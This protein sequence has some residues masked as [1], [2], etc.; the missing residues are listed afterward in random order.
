[1]TTRMRAYQILLAED[2]NPDILLVQAAL[3]RLPLECAVQVIR[4]GAQAVNYIERIDKAYRRTPLDLALVDLYLPGQD[5]ETVIRR[6]RS[7]EHYAQ[8]PVIVISGSD[9]PRDYET[10]QRHAALHYFHKPANV[11]EFMQLGRIVKGVLTGR[12]QVQGAG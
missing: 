2:S 6:L 11:S 4:D 10:A 3:S 12:T 7:T 5:G 9:S 8:T 1:M